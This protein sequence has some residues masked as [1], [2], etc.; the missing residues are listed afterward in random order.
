MLTLRFREEKEEA[1]KSYKKKNS[2]IF[3]KQ[4]E[5]NLYSYC[6]QLRKIY[7]FNSLVTDSLRRINP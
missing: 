5:T 2:H 6:H 4:G 3:H 7:A 1:E